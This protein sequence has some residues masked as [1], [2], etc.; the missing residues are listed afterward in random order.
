MSQIALWPLVS[1][2]RLV[3]AFRPGEPASSE[4]PFRTLRKHGWSTPGVR[5]TPRTSGRAEG[6]ITIF[7]VL[8]LEAARLARTSNA[9][10]AE[11]AAKWA[12]KIESS[13]AFKSF[14][15]LLAHLPA[16]SVVAISGGVIPSDAPDELISVLRR[17]AGETHELWQRSPRDTATSEIITGRITDVETHVVTL[18]PMKGLSTTLPRW[19]AHAAHR[20]SVCECLSV[21]VEQFEGSSAL[22][23]ALPA[24]DLDSSPRRFNPFDRDAPIGDLTPDDVALLRRKPKAL[25]VLVPVT[26]GA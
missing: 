7:S 21:V 25:R 14:C 8:N 26:I 18:K 19:L 1:R 5:L 12:A 6:R 10:G 15:A 3:W 11:R 20:E 22:T 9:T 16:A 24:L 17:V 4:G 13:A 23:Y 2:D